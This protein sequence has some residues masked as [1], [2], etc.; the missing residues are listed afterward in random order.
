MAFS[1]PFGIQDV[2]S[3]FNAD[4]PQELGGTFMRQVAQ[5]PTGSMSLATF[6][7]KSLNSNRQATA[8]F[9]AQAGTYSG[10]F[11]VSNL[12]TNDSNLYVTALTSTGVQY[13]V[14]TVDLGADVYVEYFYLWEAGSYDTGFNSGQACEWWVVAYNTAGTALYDNAWTTTTPGP[15]NNIYTGAITL[16]YPVRR[17]EI[18]AQHITDTSGNLKAGYFYLDSL[19]VVGQS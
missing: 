6:V 15:G 9:T 8:T 4:L 2:A 18:Y 12:S 16:A 1:L 19:L 7:G 3:A 5:Q 11:P 10:S 13:H 17:F 14:A